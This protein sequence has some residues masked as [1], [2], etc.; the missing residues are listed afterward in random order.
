MKVFIADGSHLG[1]S[2]LLALLNGIK[3]FT[4]VGYSADAVSTVVSIRTT[5]PDVVILDLDIHGGGIQVIKTIK[6]E[7][8]AIILIILTNASGEQYRNRCKELGAEFFL[9]KSSEFQKIPQIIAQLDEYL[10]APK[11][12]TPQKLSTNT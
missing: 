10:S 8:P 9:D 4:L 7:F 1:L 6:Q 11:K 5:K 2:R 3:Q 12:L